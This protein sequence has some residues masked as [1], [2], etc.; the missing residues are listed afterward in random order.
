MSEFRISAEHIFDG[1]SIAPK[2]LVIREGVIVDV[3][4]TD[5]SAAQ[6]V[7]IITPGFVDLQVNGGG[8]VLWNADPTAQGARNIA[9]A[10]RSLGTIGI[11]PT[12]ITD[13]PEVMAR[14]VEAMIELWGDEA[15]LGVHLEGPHINPVKRGTHAEAF[16]RPMEQETKEHVRQLREHGVPV[17][18][19]LAPE[20]V[21]PSDIAELA[22]LGVMVSLGHSNATSGEARK[23]L[24]AGA[25]VVTHLYNAMSQMQGREAG[26]TGAAINSDAFVGII[27]DGHHVSPEMLA[28][29]CRARPVRDRMFLVS[30]AMPTVAGPE[31]FRLYDM[32][33]RV[34]NGRLVNPEGAL[35]GAHVCMAESVAYLVNTVGIL[36]EEALRMAVTVPATLLERP[37]LAGLIGRRTKDILCLSSDLRVKATLEDVLRNVAI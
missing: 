5:E 1:Q 26:L 29:A 19:T 28:L 20:C 17:M 32:E 11:M 24:Q 31:S 36:P 4:E 14:A 7:G 18:L 8:G 30:D 16:V 9:K 27:A 34:E 15:I 25:K 23:G 3:C 12:L 21:S 37:D 33:I 13:A 2:G 10:H 6:I 35:A 22:R